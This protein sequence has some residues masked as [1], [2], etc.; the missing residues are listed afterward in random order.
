MTQGLASFNVHPNATTTGILNEFVIK[1]EVGHILGLGTLWELNNLY[2]VGTGQYTGAN[3]VA[4]YNNE[5]GQS[6]SF[7]P[8]ELDGSPGTAN[9][10]WNEVTD[11]FAIED[12][13]GFDAQPGD[14]GP[15]P[16]VV[17]GPNIG[18]SLDDALMT[19]VLSGSTF[20]SDTTLGSLRDLGYTT[21]E[22]NVKTSAIPE[23]KSL[24]LGALA[25]CLLMSRRHRSSP[26]Q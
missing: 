19:G 20:L 7:V 22:P 23:P 14:G 10:H 2:D 17:N 26:K 11:N 12:V 5:F 25:A 21:I 1:H 8:V 4:F 24:V 16:T 15:A 3:G 9:G 13:A 18:E 6:G